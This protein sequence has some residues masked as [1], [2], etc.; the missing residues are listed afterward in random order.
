MT[1]IKTLMQQLPEAKLIV[2]LLEFINKNYLSLMML[3]IL[4][5]IS[6]DRSYNPNIKVYDI[7]NI[8]EA[9]S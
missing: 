8:R 3:I 6:S 7:F 4:F 5:R 2:Q 1:N 9:F